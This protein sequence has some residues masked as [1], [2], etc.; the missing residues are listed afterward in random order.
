MNWDKSW[1][2]SLDRHAAKCRAEEERQQPVR[3]RLTKLNEPLPY[4]MVVRKERSPRGKLLLCDPEVLVMRIA[5]RNRL[6]RLLYELE[7]KSI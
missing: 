3:E 6:Q 4:D 1:Q 7:D 5:E 2:W